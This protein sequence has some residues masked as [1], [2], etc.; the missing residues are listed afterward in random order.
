MTLVYTRLPN[1]IF[2]ISIQIEKKISTIYV[3]NIEFKIQIN[4]KVSVHA[5]IVL[6]IVNS[7]RSKHS[8]FPEQNVFEPPLGSY[9][10]K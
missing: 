8:K 6:L 5:T 7:S 2:L 10:P 9:G 4:L 1:L 3:C